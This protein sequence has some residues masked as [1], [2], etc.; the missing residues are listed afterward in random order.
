MSDPPPVSEPLGESEKQPDPVA[1]PAPEEAAVGPVTSAAP[2]SAG[3]DRQHVV[4]EL[5]VARRRDRVTGLAI[6][7]IAFV[8]GLGISL[9]AKKASRP[10]VAEPPGP[11]TV[12]GVVGFPTNV[13]VLKS[14]NGARA[15]TRRPIL[16]NITIEGVRSDGTI[17]LSEGP[18]RAR[19]VFQSAEGQGAQPPRE[20]GSLPRRHYCGKQTVH[21]RSEGLVADP[22]ITDYPCPAQHTDALPEPRCTLADVWAHAVKNGAPKIEWPASSTTAPARGRPGASS[23]RAL[24]TNTRC[25]GIAAGSSPSPRA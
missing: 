10:E 17:D 21:L 3:G 22:D 12:G 7:I 15:V 24:P 18:G 4:D 5:E 16:R 1:E 11:P 25:M 8:I 13:D 23:F 6:L 19:Y 14:L 2:P 20:P 9:W